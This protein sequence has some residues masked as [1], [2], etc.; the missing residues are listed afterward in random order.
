MPTLRYSDSG[1]FFYFFFFLSLHCFGFS[2][3]NAYI[4]KLL[5]ESIW[6]DWYAVYDSCSIHEMLVYSSHVWTMKPKIKTCK[7]N[8][9]P[10]RL[11][12]IFNFRTNTARIAFETNNLSKTFVQHKFSGPVKSF[13]VCV[14]V[15]FKFISHKNQ[16]AKRLF[17][18]PKG[19]E[20]NRQTFQ[21]GLMIDILLVFMHAF[22]N[23]WF[24]RSCSLISR[25]LPTL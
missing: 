13:S 18:I 12:A 4:R 9:E 14:C 17:G 24:L 3:T 1:A 11:I 23:I 22:G 6:T 2:R 21:M 19:M 8:C 16:F 5:I 7:M 10:P 20:A 15:C 25:V